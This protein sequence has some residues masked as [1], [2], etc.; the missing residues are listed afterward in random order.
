R[1]G[2][3][4]ALTRQGGRRVRS[5]RLGNNASGPCAGPIGPSNVAG[6]GD[7]KK[8]VAQQYRPKERRTL[9]PH[10]PGGPKGSQRAARQQRVGPLRRADRPEQRR[11]PRRQ[12][13]GC[14]AAVSPKGAENPRPSPAR[15]AEGFAAGGSA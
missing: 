3:P 13:E 4:S 14:S 8:V 7:N 15:G 11:R 10:P 5:G 2:E 9:G 6:P 12:Q 1:S